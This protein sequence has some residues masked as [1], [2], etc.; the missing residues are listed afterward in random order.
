MGIL[1]VT[2]NLHLFAGIFV[3]ER[4]YFSGLPVQAKKRALKQEGASFYD[5]KG[6]NTADLWPCCGNWTVHRG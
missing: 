3:E 4:E 2:T 1:R 5:V 6:H